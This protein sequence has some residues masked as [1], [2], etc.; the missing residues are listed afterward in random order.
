MRNT[1]ISILLSA[2]CLLFSAAAHTQEIDRELINRFLD[3]VTRENK[4]LGSLLITREG[5][6][7]YSR[8]FG[9]TGTIQDTLQKSGKYRIGS[10]T[11]LFTA[12]LIRRLIENGE[13]DPQ[14][15]LDHYFPDIPNSGKINITHLLNH[16][17]GLGDYVM[18][19]DTMLWGM[20]PLTEQEILNEIKA[21]GV[22]FEPGAGIKYSNS[23]YFLLT[24]ILEK[25]HGK[26]YPQI[27]SEQ[28]LIPLKMEQTLSGVREDATIL[29]SC[30][31]NPENKWEKTDEFCFTNFTGLGDIAA[32]PGDL[33]LFI[34]ALFSGKLVPERSL[35]KMLPQEGQRYGQGIMQSPFR[36]HILYGHGGATLGT[37]SIVLYDRENKLAVVACI[38]GISAPAEDI[39]AGIF[40]GI[41]PGTN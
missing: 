8:T 25:I 41:Y 2:V 34:H 14:Q 28:I 38:N 24:R 27:V 18:K 11:K 36:S 10:N 12:V 4:G 33:A 31:L 35:Q 30:R 6:P 3:E 39:W 5:N 15:T 21:Q 26:K 40:N 16:T 17:S 20:T 7:V 9:N 19:A 37:Q 23:G 13:L 1:F 29:P 32:T 22:K